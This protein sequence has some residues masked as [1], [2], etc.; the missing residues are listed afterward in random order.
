MVVILSI[1]KGQVLRLNLPNLPLLP[2]VD[3]LGC[4]MTC[5]GLT[6]SCHS[7]CVKALLINQCYSLCI[8]KSSVFMSRNEHVNAKKES[9]LWFGKMVFACYVY[10]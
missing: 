1:L 3:D 4:I 2:N 5:N 6:N 8:S 7:T 9:R 10:F